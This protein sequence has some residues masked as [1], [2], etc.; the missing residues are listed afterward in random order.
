MTSPDVHNPTLEKP[1]SKTEFHAELDKAAAKAQA[2]GTPLSIAFIDLDR[3]KEVNDK[4]GHEV[5]DTVIEDMGMLLLEPD[6]V[7]AGHIGGDEF[8][9]LSETDEGGIQALK[10]YVKKIF[11][12]N[13]EE[14][15]RY[16]EALRKIG[17]QPS[18]GVATLGPGMSTSELLREAD[19]AMYKEKKDKLDFGRRQKVALFIARIALQ[20]VG[21]IRLRDIGKYESI[22]TK[23]V[24]S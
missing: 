14:E 2:Q 21:G 17:V 5:G 10:D 13:L 4:L 11:A 20:K 15:G 1:L 3:F 8:A 16:K 6:S 24:K 9:L 12:G 19:E 7:I 23:R 18:I 22:I